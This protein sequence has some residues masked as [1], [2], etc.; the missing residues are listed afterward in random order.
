MHKNPLFAQRLARFALLP[1]LALLAALAFPLPSFLAYG[2]TLSEASAVAEQAQ[3]KA[4][5][6]TPE[7][8]TTQRLDYRVFRVVAQTQVGGRDWL[9]EIHYMDNLGNEF[10]DAHYGPDV[11]ADPEADPPI[12]AQRNAEFY[13]RAFNMMNFSTRSL[14]CRALDH[15]KGK[16]KIPATAV[17]CGG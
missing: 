15:L 2:L 11:L 8:T 1:M 12:E 4:V 6:A 3:E 17:V 7:V 13:V 5:L 9:F 10:S 14:V 16:G